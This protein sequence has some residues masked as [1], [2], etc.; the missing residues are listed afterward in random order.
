[1]AVEFG[2]GMLCITLITAIYA[3]VTAFL[4]GRYNEQRLVEFARLAMALVF[5]LLS[6][7]RYLLA[8]PFEIR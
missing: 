2:Y 1:M 7:C 3:V 8:L 5:P 6:Y 4:G